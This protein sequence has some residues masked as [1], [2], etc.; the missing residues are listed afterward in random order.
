MFSRLQCSVL[1]DSN[2]S[3]SRFPEQNVALRIEASRSTR[4]AGFQPQSIQ[5]RRQPEIGSHPFDRVAYHAW[6]RK[7]TS[8][9][10]A[11]IRR[12]ILVEIE[13]RLDYERHREE[14]AA[15]VES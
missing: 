8:A 14:L 3:R 15:C 2:G 13:R 7:P 6:L 9:A 12:D 4:C 11:Q 1:L 10:G 5:A